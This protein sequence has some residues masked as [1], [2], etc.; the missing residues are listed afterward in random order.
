MS[1]IR[2][3]EA[4]KGYGIGF[5][6]GQKLIAALLTASKDQVLD[7]I[8]YIKKS[9]NFVFFDPKYGDTLD[10]IGGATELIANHGVDLISV[11][12]SAGQD[13]MRGAIEKA[14]G[15][16]RI[17]GI[18]VLTSIGDAEC[19]VIF[20]DERAIVVPRLVNHGLEAGV[21][22][23]VMSAKEVEAMR[24]VVGDGKIL[25]AG[26]KLKGGQANRGQKAVGT[27]EDAAQ[28][29]D[30]L[31]TGMPWTRWK[32]GGFSSPQAAL[33]A[34]LAEIAEGAQRRAS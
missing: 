26:L 3:I 34:I 10:Q 15:S 12:T 25:V 24:P 32:E 4:F 30:F 23:F 6:I 5:K 21:L 20:G 19:K 27:F 22:N 7:L 33:E 29:A 31:V 1:A 13:M 14:G 17:I 8:A 9:G 18:T 28:F 11:H 16:D 2:A